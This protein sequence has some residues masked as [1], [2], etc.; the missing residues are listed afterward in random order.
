[1]ISLGPE[2]RE[3]YVSFTAAT[4]L[5]I[6]DYVRAYVYMIATYYLRNGL[7]Q[8]AFLKMAA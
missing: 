3:L 8:K 4:E 6:L 7:G 2:T 1:M 5:D